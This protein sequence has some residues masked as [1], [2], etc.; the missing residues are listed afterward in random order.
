MA[1]DTIIGGLILY[2]QLNVA[3]VVFLFLIPPSR[4]SV[5]W[6]RR[7]LDP[8]ERFRDRPLSET[9]NTGV[10]TGPRRLR[11]R[12]YLAESGRIFLYAIGLV[13]LL[14][15][16]V[17]VLT[18]LWYPPVL[19]VWWVLFLATGMAQID[20]GILWAVFVAIVTVPIGYRVLFKKHSG[21]KND[22]S[23][24]AGN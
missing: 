19:A 16:V 7:R 6:L 18:G 1:S 10:V 8:Y 24:L 20:I 2:L 23:G 5:S 17:G 9:R 22:E 11:S 15:T 14:G 12:Y 13:F 3:F 4:R 21:K